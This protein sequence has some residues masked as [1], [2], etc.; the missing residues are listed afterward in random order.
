MK[1][2]PEGCKLVAANTGDGWS[3]EVFYGD[4]CIAMIEWPESW[5]GIMSSDKLKEYG[6][7]VA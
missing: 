3:L 2:I 7:E 5:P 4:E 1:P 6:W